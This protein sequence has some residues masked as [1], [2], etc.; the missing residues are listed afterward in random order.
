M[1]T[2]PTTAPRA[3]TPA[4]KAKATNKNCLIYKY[5]KKPARF[6]AGFFANKT[7]HAERAGKIDTITMERHAS[8][9]L[10]MTFFLVPLK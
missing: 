7:S 6:L 9:A 1:R 3:A 4:A 10:G 8:A 2:K 5:L